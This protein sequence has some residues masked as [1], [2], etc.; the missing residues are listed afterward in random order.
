[1]WSREFLIRGADV[2]KKTMSWEK[3]LPLE[4]A[5]YQFAMEAKGKNFSGMPLRVGYGLSA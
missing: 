3:S 2:R 5:S 4:R 1:M